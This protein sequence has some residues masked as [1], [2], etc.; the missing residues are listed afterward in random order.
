M[1]L[2]QLQRKMMKGC[3]Y[4]S[5]QRST[6]SDIK[7][8]MH[9]CSRAIS[10]MSLSWIRAAAASVHHSHG[11]ARSKPYL[12]PALQLMAM[13][14]PKPTE[15]GQGSNPH[16]Q[17]YLSDSLTTAPRWKLSSVK[18]YWSAEWPGALSK[19]NSEPP[20]IGRESGFVGRRSCAEFYRSR[21]A[22]EIMV[23]MKFNFLLG[24]ILVLGKST[25]SW[26]WLFHLWRSTK[27]ETM[28]LGLDGSMNH[29]TFPFSGLPFCF[30][31]VTV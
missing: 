16:P 21:M 17:G 29:E 12:Q 30:H 6:L 19:R 8:S 25:I 4:V 23:C 18:I 24:A 13:P 28:G 20:T 7:S 26:A 9:S 22:V 14:D 5:K 1:S 2:Q 27:V 11:N 10:C 31:L 15:Q 3:T